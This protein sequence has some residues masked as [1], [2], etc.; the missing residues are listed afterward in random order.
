[1]AVFRGSYREFLGYVDLEGT[2]AHI[3]ALKLAL[4]DLLEKQYIMYQ[5]DKTNEEYFIA[6]LYRAVEEELGV[7][8]AT[9]RQCKEVAEKY[10]KKN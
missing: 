5:V 1:M 4:K 6:G 8:I 10:N 7:G 3:S 9:I 2:S